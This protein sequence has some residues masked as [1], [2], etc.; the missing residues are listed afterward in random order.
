M[1]NRI[2]NPVQPPPLRPLPTPTI[3]PTNHLP[4][5]T[6]DIYHPYPLLG[7]KPAIPWGW[8]FTPIDPGLAKGHVISM[9]QEPAAH[10][11]FIS[12]AEQ[13]A[14]EHAAAFIRAYRASHPAATFAGLAGPAMR[15]AGCYC[16]H[17]MTAKS[18]MAFA[19]LGRIPEAWRLLRNLADYLRHEK[20]DAAVMVDSPA[21]NLPIAKKCQ[22]AGTP[23]LYYIA[24]QT[25]AWGWQWWRNR[26]VRKRINRIA[27][28]WP[29]EEGYFRDR[30][31]RADY[32]GH[33]SFDHLLGVTPSD[34]DVNR[35]R[36]NASPLITLLPGSR[37]H[38]I[39]EVLPGQLDVAAALA[40]RHRG[41]KFVVA[42]SSEESRTLIESII[43]GR[44]RTLP[45]RIVEGALNRAAAIVAAD[46]VLVASG[47]VTL[48]VAYRNAPMIVMYNGSALAYNLIGRWLITTPHL[49][50]PNILA[51]REIVPEFMPYY[52]SVDPII[53]TAVEW[54]S[55]PGKLDKVRH[56]LAATIQPLVKSGAA[57][58]T[59]TILADML[60]SSPRK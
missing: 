3:Q 46:I 43:R 23:V 38:V 41:I 35:L 49:S 57:E 12:A 50:I 36:D 60:R 20:F 32:V 13:S 54:L 55:T 11:I 42:A 4:P 44:A 21:L 2:R 33:P 17:D 48:E 24:P 18:A 37:R 59:A 40:I 45:L 15:A 1:E 5:H 58:N 27:C 39:E 29:F 53:A 34:E 47:T 31:I 7:Y 8:S 6:S 22:L 9:S 14:D 10:R 19:A 25:W 52:R 56:D 26:R 30:G 51:G 16:F 28:L